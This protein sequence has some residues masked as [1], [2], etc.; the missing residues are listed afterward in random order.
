MEKTKD[1]VFPEDCLSVRFVYESLMEHCEKTLTI[2]FADG[3]W[4]NA[5]A[6]MHEAEVTVWCKEADLSAL[7]LGSCELASM[8]GMDGIHLSD[9]GFVKRLDRLLHC[10]QKPY[11]NSDY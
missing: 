7:L 5:D 6:D 2:E 4:K 1:R 8:V 9:N 3:G 11:S 10:D